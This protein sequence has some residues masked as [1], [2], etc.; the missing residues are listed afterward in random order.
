MR[1]AAAEGRDDAD[2]VENR[3][4]LAASRR[5]AEQSAEA[6]V[7]RTRETENPVRDQLRF[8]KQSDRIAVGFE[9]SCEKLGRLQRYRPQRGARYDVAMHPLEGIEVGDREQARLTLRGPLDDPRSVRKAKLLE[10][11]AHPCIRH[12]AGSRR[13]RRL[14]PEVSQPPRSPRSRS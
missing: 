12:R 8:E 3:Q 5:Q 4:A 1:A 2:A 7:L 9:V 6:A 14:G 10:R 13:D 11:L